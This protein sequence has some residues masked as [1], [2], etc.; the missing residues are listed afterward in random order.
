[1][2]SIS[3][4][5]SYLR[6]R[7]FSREFKAQ[8]VAQCLEPGVSVSRIALN[9]DLNANLVRRWISE[10][11]QTGSHPSPAFVPLSLPAASPGSTKPGDKRSPIRIEIPRAGG[12]VV[13]EWPAD[14]AQQCLAL[15]RE[16]LR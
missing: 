12:P 7:R 10:A 13:V 16:L 1:M 8:V 4:T 9:N 5:K 6:R 14:Q 3:D 15:L 11:R 2:S